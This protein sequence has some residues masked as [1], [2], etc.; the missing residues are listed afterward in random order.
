MLSRFKLNQVLMF[1]LVFLSAESF[2]DSPKDK[3][4]A[5]IQDEAKNCGLL[6]YQKDSTKIK[7]CIVERLNLI[8]NFYAWFWFSAGDTQPATGLLMKDGLLY[9]G[10]YDKIGK[11]KDSYFQTHL[12]D[13]WEFIPDAKKP[14]QCV[15]KKSAVKIY[16][17][18]MDNF[19]E[20][21]FQP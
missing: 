9:I 14:L 12:C 19:V 16:L 8:E 17:F 10:W 6:K 11:G 3:S 20:L 4:I 15:I 2:A 1:V 18:E 13:S 7:Q 5:F 21:K